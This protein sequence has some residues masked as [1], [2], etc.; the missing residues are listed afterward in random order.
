MKNVFKIFKNIKT[1]LIFF[2]FLILIIPAIVIGSLAYSTAKSAVKHEI[3]S[4]FAQ[5]I[6]VLN[7]SIDNTIQSK[8]QDVDNF[9]KS[10]TSQQY[11][12]D[13]STKLRQQF[14]Q[15]VK[16]HPEALS[17][18]LG[19]GTGLLIQEPKVTLPSGFDPRERDWYKGAMDKK[20][21]V[22]ISDPYKSADTGDMV[23]TISQSTKDGSGV[24]AVDISLKY[25]QELT[26]QVRIGD[27]G[28]ALLLDKN[29]KYIAH[30]TSTVGSE[31]KED[32]YAQMYEK[33]KGQFDYELEG[34]QKVMSFIT[35]ETTGWKIA[36][37]VYSSEISA[38]AAPI[39]QKT[40]LV[41]AIALIIGAIVI[42]FVIK[43]IL[44]PI[45]KLKENAITISKGD[46]TE[47]IHVQS[48]D[49]IGQL[50]HAFQD[51]QES[52]KGLVQ[53][54]EQNAEQV[55]SSA[56]ELTA[57]AEQTSAA[58]GQV[59]IAI[60]EVAG[61]A[62]KQMTGVD[63]NSESLLEVS[64]G[65]TRIAH[66]S[67]IVSE[68]AHLTT[69]QAEAGGKAITDTVNQMNSIHK[70]VM[71]S[72][73]MI[74]SLNDRSKE[75][76]SILSVI[77][78]IADQTN[79]LAL[80]AAIEAARAGEHGKGFAVVA[81]EVRKLAEQS[82]R[83]AKEVHEIVQKIQEDTQSSVQI[84]AR[85]TDDV[86]AGV[87]VSNEAIE[88]FN[89]ILQS[90]KEITPQMEEVSA[91]AQQMSA[92][93]QEVTTTANQLAIIAKGNACNFRRSGS[94]YGGAISV[95]GGNFCI[96]TISFRYGRNIK[97][98]NLSI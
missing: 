58:T 5:T 33:E 45:R 30:P 16:L 62:E 94:V 20:G 44:S 56:E 89:Q 85:V 36:G 83:S 91:I 92:S 90:T 55:A 70:S 52:L 81:D 78:G 6:N 46:L 7:S 68:L 82:Q 43:S 14:D 3:L 31:A 24:V 80:N 54:V 61:S 37:N 32:F 65:V 87:Q 47:S 38:A 95:Y 39:F 64:E 13:R 57:S 72:N 79:L 2:F 1:K 67:M 76:N 21:E 26:N 63:K 74:Q 66:N 50:A 42:F 73:T 41:I 9:S 97:E 17:I 48:N 35:N 34:K 15:Y 25:L 11:S 75:V 53:E 28:Y 18:Y 23:I 40:V 4:G 51:M 8:K 98:I 49:E 27:K 84:M 88:K 86:Q 29:R 69:M 12:G 60:Q 96:S 59:A 10:V 71:E 19:A 77:T 93:V 22:I